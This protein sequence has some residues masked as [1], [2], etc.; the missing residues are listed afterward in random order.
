MGHHKAEA[1]PS[2]VDG[3]QRAVSPDPLPG[4]RGTQ[5]VLM[6]FYMLHTRNLHHKNA[7]WWRQAVSCQAY[8]V[9]S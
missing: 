2:A 9:T 6:G 7:C 1:N 4:E 8:E 3:D 5:A